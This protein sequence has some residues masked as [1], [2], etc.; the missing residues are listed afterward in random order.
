MNTKD[1]IDKKR[2]SQ[3]VLN[4]LYIKLEKR[5]ELAEAATELATAD[6]VIK[7]FA[8]MAVED[9]DKTKAV[10]EAAVTALA[11]FHEAMKIDRELDR[12]AESN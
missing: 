7:K 6:D 10:L 8:A 9:I 3:M 4:S 1:L 12:R 5:P 11:N 2:V